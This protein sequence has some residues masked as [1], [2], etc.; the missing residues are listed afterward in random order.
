MVKEPAL[1]SL[2]QAPSFVETLFDRIPEVVF[3]I[4]DDEGRYRMVN[5]TLVLRCG[6]RSKNDLLGRTAR[7]VFP[8]PLGERFLEQDLQVL[9][10]AAPI[11]QNLELHL[12][13]TR[14][15]GWCLTDK[16]PLRDPDGRVIGLAGISRAA[17]KPALTSIPRRSA[18][19]R[20]LHP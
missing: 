5:Q 13:P 15:E 7:E 9:E 2:I 19:W 18:S 6:K 10:T 8:P 3:F 20:S 16:E 14:I 1:N 4:K 12:Y 17:E 11:S